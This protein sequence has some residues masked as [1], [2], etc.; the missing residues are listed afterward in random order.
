M[1]YAQLPSCDEDVAAFQDTERHR[2][3]NTNNLWIN[4]AALRD[5]LTARNDLMDL[6][7]TANHK[8]VDPA[9]AGS[10]PVVQLESATGS[11]LGTWPGARAIRVPRSRF[12]P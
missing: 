12:A 5:L 8:T 1:K 11:A 4:L 2:F 6:P 7:F 3:F 9:D 10:T